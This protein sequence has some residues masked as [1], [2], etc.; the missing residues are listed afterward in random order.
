[1]WLWKNIIRFFNIIN[2][3]FFNVMMSF[4]KIFHK[5]LKNQYNTL[6]MDSNLAVVFLEFLS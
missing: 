4:E 5:S 2:I 3:S 6:H 1:M